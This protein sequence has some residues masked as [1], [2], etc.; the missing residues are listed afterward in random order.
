MK[1][2]WNMPISQQQQAAIEGRLKSK[3]YVEVHQGGICPFCRGTEYE[4]DSFDL[5]DGTAIQRLHCNECD[6][7]WYDVYTLTRYEFAFEDVGE[8]SLAIKTGREEA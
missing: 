6:S 5:E 1:K 7:T 4:G 2:E 3:E 8:E